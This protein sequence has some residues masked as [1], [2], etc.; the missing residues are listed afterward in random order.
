MPSKMQPTDL[1]RFHF[2]TSISRL[3]ELVN[4]MYLY[5]QEV[6]PGSAE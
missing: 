1:D 4:E 5:V 6:S 3:M 2:N